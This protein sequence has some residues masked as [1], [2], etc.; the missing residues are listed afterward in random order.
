LLELVQKILR[1][2]RRAVHAVKFIDSKPRPN[3]EV[4]ARKVTTN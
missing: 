4:R 2:P 1:F 3:Y